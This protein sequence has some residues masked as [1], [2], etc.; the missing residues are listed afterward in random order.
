MMAHHEETKRWAATSVGENTPEKSLFARRLSNQIEL[1]PQDVI[2]P[3][4]KSQLA[5]TKKLQLCQNDQRNEKS[6]ISS[7][8]TQNKEEASFF[9]H[10]EEP[11]TNLWTF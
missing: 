1:L 2:P 4:N 6:R 5:T 11:S 9:R 3:R 7:L 10:E 8:A